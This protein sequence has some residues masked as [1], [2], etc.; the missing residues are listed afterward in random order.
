VDKKVYYFFLFLLLSYPLYSTSDLVVKLLL[1]E[2]LLTVCS[3]DLIDMSNST[4]SA[5]QSTESLDLKMINLEEIAK[6]LDEY[7]QQKLTAYQESYKRQEARYQTLE[8]NYKADQKQNDGLKMDLQNYK[9]STGISWTITG[10]VTV[11]AVIIVILI[12]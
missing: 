8:I 10:I 3:N 9:K 2:S 6:K 11:A 4:Q 12:K 1:Q 7:I 5:L